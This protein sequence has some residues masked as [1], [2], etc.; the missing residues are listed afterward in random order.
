MHKSFKSHILASPVH[1]FEISTQKHVMLQEIR[2][3]CEDQDQ[4]HGGQLVVAYTF[5]EHREMGSRILF[6]RYYA[7]L[8]FLVLFAET[9]RKLTITVKRKRNSNKAFRHR[10]SPLC[11]HLY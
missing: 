7:V 6:Y 5:Q 9:N 1:L 2:K 10:F 4:H 3:L 11:R 8:G